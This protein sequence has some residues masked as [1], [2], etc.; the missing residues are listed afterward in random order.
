ME[1]GENTGACSLNALGRHQKNCAA[2]WKASSRSWDRER[3]NSG[4]I[5]ARPGPVS[6]CTAFSA[7]CT[8][9]ANGV[10]EMAYSCCLNQGVMAARDVGGAEEGR[11]GVKGADELW[12]LTGDLLHLLH[13]VRDHG[14]DA[15]EII[16]QF[17]RTAKWD[18]GA[19]VFRDLRDVIVIGADDHMIKQPRLQRRCDGPA[20]HG[21]AMEGAHILARNAFRAAARRD[22]R[23]L[24]GQRFVLSAMP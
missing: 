17:V 12:R 6:L 16:R 24:H 13:G 19:G 22:D 21:A 2:S 10:T 4:Y 18:A 14:D 20:D 9:N 15:G 8:G 23:D 3:M 1:R 5:G 11:G 7:R